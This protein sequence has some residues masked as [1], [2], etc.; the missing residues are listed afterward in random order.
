MVLDVAFHPEQSDIFASCSEDGQIILWDLRLPKPAYGIFNRF[1]GKEWDCLI[2]V[3]CSYLL[4]IPKHFASRPS[5]VTFRRKGQCNLLVGTISGHVLEVDVSSKSS[6]YLP[7][8]EIGAHGGAV[9]KLF[10]A[11][12]NDSLVATCAD[13]H[14]VVISSVDTA[15]PHI[16]YGFLSC[17]TFQF[18][19]RQSKNDFQIFKSFF[20]FSK[21]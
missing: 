16:M 20:F 1:I 13:D 2:N 5:G 8:L 6:K 4:A 17:V 14:K 7:M 3:S 11:P 21:L 12:H 15:H 10:V 18:G 19:W 9:R